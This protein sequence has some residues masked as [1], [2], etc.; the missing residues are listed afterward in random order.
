MAECLEARPYLGFLF[1]CYSDPTYGGTIRPWKRR[2]PRRLEGIGASQ[3][4]AR[5]QRSQ[6]NPSAVSLQSVPA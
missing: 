3:Q 6:V 2:C 4:P 5:C 1:R